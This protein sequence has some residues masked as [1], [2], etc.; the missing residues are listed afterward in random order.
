VYSCTDENPAILTYLVTVLHPYPQLRGGGGVPSVELPLGLLVLHP[1]LYEELGSVETLLRP[2]DGHYPV[3]GARAVG[4]LLRDLNVGSTELL[5]LHNRA[6]SR[7][8]DCANQ[9]LIHLNVNFR[10]LLL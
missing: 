8:K 1:L 3:P 9:A 7:P 6:T 10:E 5:D 2:G 4:A